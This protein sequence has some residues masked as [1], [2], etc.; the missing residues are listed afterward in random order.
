MKKIKLVLSTLFFCAMVFANSLNCYGLNYCD[1]LTYTISEK[2][3]IITGF[4]GNPEII[5]LPSK[6]DGLTVTGIR[7]N[8]FYKCDS[9]KEIVIPKS[10]SAIGHHTFFE[11]TSLESVEIKGSIPKISEGLFYGC[12]K[13]KS[14]T[15]NSSPST[16]ENYAFFGCN[17]LTSFELPFNVTDI[18]SYSFADCYELS[19]ISLNNRLK[20]IKPYSFYNCISLEKIN[21]P[22]SLLSIGQCAI[23]YSDN[24]ISDK[25]TITGTSDSIAKCYAENSSLKFKNR[26][27]YD[28]HKSLDASIITGIFEWVLFAVVYVLLMIA[29]LTKT[30][31][32]KRTVAI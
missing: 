21:L 26:V 9:L 14:V 25:I 1:S 13:L 31:I 17:S 16:V 6:I 22:D 27:Y 15:I 29:L 28:N 4:R 32:S 3:A 7:E 30:K 20:T 5:N 8:A 11:C 2:E 24:G 10:V 19:R 12:K 18:G 23:G